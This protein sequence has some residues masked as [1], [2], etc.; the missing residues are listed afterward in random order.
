VAIYRVA[1]ALRSE[2]PSRRCPESGIVCWSQMMNC[3]PRTKQRR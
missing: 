2:W 1:S 3:R